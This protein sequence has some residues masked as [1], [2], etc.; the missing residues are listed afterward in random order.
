MPVD[1]EG[2]NMSIYCLI[3]IYDNAPLSLVNIHEIC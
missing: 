3:T 1:S 2:K